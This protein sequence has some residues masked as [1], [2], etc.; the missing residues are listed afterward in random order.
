MRQNLCRQG[1]R[2][3]DRIIQNHHLN[4]RIFDI[5]W[6]DSLESTNNYCKLLDLNTVEEFTVICA[7][8]QTAGI[9]QQGNHWAS[10]PGKNL[11][12]SL[13]LKPTFLRA[14]DQY[15]L[16]MA[17]ALAIA[18][19]LDLLISNPK[20]NQFAP[21]G[22]VRFSQRNQFAP[23]G[24]VRFSQRNQFAPSGR[25][26]FSQR[27]QFTP[28]GRIQIKW[29]NDIYVG[30]PSEQHYRKICGILV[31][32]QLSGSH[33]ATSIC[34]IG[35]NVNQTCF[36]TWVPN[37]TSLLLEASAPPSPTPFAIDTVLD[38]VLD[39][40]LHR[41]RQLSLHDGPDAIKTDYLSRL[42]RLGQ[43][44]SYFYNGK[45]IR[46]TI[47]GIDHFGHLLLTTST[48]SHLSCALKE[49]SFL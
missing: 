30:T 43:E 28:S 22:R 31:T 47:T 35:L 15:S 1:K 17:I 23:S 45:T 12:F 40:I 21:S 33:I 20:N 19:T 44:A 41:Y 29:P 9:G 25:V 49:I 38:T 2:D 3:Y 14:A 37:P 32:N 42:Y 10:E 48:G 18:D 24:R 36:P 6:F 46:A 13:I 34:G 39:C 27:N 26:R 16:T 5:R 7:R 11:T 8:S 4:Y